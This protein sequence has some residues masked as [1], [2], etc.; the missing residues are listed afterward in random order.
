MTSFNVRPVM[1]V[2]F[3][4]LRASLSWYHGIGKFVNALKAL[5]HPKFWGGVQSGVPLAGAAGEGPPL[6]VVVWLRRALTQP[7]GRQK[8]SFVTRRRRGV[9]GQS[10]F[11]IGKKQVE[12]IAPSA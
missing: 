8:P 11:V 4:G 10:S 3:N 6:G 5:A 1:W 7:D 12:T 9:I 2:W